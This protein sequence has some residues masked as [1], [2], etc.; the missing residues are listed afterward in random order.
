VTSPAPARRTPAP[1]ESLRAYRS[2]WTIVGRV[3]VIGLVIGLVAMWVY[4]FWGSPDV[5]GRLSDT[6]FPTAAEPVCKATKDRID[7]LPKAFTTPDAAQRADVVDRATTDLEA[8]VTELR[9]KV[10]LVPTSAERD[11]VNPWL[12]DWARY[13]Q[14]RREYTVALRADPNTRFIVTQSERDKTQ[15]TGAL[16]RFAKIN[17]MA[18]CIIPDDL[19]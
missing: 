8:M 6:T 14:D 18:S 3:A 2:P 16:D 10:A 1:D 11:M 19:A 7:A 13:N 4:A 9:A 15:I 12:D 5:P 17:N